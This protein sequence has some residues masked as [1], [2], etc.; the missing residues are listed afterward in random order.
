MRAQRE[1][2]APLTIDYVPIA[3]LRPDPS[4]PRRISDDELETLTR[5]IQQ[6]DIVDPVIARRQ[7][8][9]VIGGHQRLLAAR[10]LGFETVP[11]VFLDIT[12]DN[13]RLLNLALN[14][15]SGSWDEELLAQLL[16]E[17]QERPDVD[18]SLSGFDEHEIERL[19]TTLD[20]REQRYREETFDLGAAW[21]A[22][23]ADLGVER[24]DVWQLGRH[25]IMCGDST[26][27]ADVGLLMAGHTAAAMVADPPYGVAYEPG[28]KK[29][30]VGRCRNVPIANDNLGREQA[31]FWT[32][33][34][35]YWPLNGDAY[36]F[37]PSGPL[38]SAL[39]AA[40]EAAGIRH[41]QWLIWVKDRLVLGRSHYHYRHEHVFYGW[42]GKSSWQG[43]RKEDS[44]WDEPRPGDSPGHPTIKPLPLC[45]KAIENSSQ[46][47]DL[48]VD[49]FLGSGTTLIAAERT[50]RR[51]FGMEID[52]RYVRLALS[53]WEAFTESEAR[54]LTNARGGG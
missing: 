22:A 11:V 53:R 31:A 25:R 27:S 44:V 9:T 19:L 47:N 17:L 14:K 20:I 3:D 26:E 45:E 6:F 7:D 24:G 33:A 4:N 43:S 13:A 39:C 35:R 30:A 37:S 23:K 41:H 49:P 28:A 48:V 5:S 36:V 2:A 54:K 38:I 15:I 1:H 16:T 50:G 34:F 8:M 12:V 51:C 18:I 32:A 52:P 10:R 40:I 46:P 21:I 42:K 29:P